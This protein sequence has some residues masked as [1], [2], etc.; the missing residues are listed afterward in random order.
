MAANNYGTYY[1]NGEEIFDDLGWGSGHYAEYWNEEIKFNSS[2]L[3]EGKNV[4]AS[5]VR[6]TGNTQ[7]FDEELVTVTP[8]SSAWGFQPEYLSL[9]LEV[10]PVYAFELVTPIEDK[11]VSEDE[12][13]C[14]EEWTYKF[15]IWLYNLSLIHI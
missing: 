14:D 6:E 8:K 9:K 5:V 11:A 7:W 4:L 2:I 15:E 13:C 1:L 3:K 12:A 10:L